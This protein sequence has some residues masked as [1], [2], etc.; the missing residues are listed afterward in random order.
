MGFEVLEEK[1]LE[2]ESEY[3]FHVILESSSIEEGKQQTLD[4]VVF[5]TALVFEALGVDELAHLREPAVPHLGISILNLRLRLLIPRLSSV[6]GLRF[7]LNM[8]A[9]FTFLGV[10]TPSVNRLSHLVDLVDYSGDKN[11]GNNHLHEEHT[12]SE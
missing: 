6:N 10:G 12:Q 7:T 11:L 9:F 1:A 2:E 4:V 5:D 3:L 8:L